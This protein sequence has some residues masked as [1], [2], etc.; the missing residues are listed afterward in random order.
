MKKRTDVG[1]GKTGPLVD[2][3][4]QIRNWVE[5]SGEDLEVAS[6]L[7]GRGRSRHGLFFAHLAMEK[8]LKAV[9]CRRTRDI[10]PP[11]H[12]LVRLAEVA[13]VELSQE[14]VDLLADVSAF[15]IE[16][17][18]PDRLA[19]PPSGEEARGYL[20]RIEETIQW[21]MKR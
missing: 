19:P 1:E 18:Y 17:R 7:I 20:A 9:V 12:N 16:T 8:A 21:L 4:K 13:G 6:E 11:I 10:A 15:N 14:Q 3:D 2:L 5:D